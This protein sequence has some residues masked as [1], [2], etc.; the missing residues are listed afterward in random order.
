[1]N[2]N[3]LHFLEYDQDQWFNVSDPDNAGTWRFGADWTGSHKITFHGSPP[4]DMI[5]KLSNNSGFDQWL[6]DGKGKPLNLP[7]EPFRLPKGEVLELYTDN[8]THKLIKVVRAWETSSSRITP[9]GGLE[10]EWL[11]KISDQDANFSWRNIDD[12]PTIDTIDMAADYVLI[13]DASAERHCKVL[14]ADLLALLGST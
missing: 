13:Y 14:L 5:I 2:V 8:A 12:L 4:N 11:A 3:R 9:F 1:M 10:G 6:I 7:L